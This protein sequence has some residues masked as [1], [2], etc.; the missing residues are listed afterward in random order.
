MNQTFW[1]NCYWCGHA[2]KVVS[3]VEPTFVVC[4]ICSATSLRDEEA[5]DQYDDGRADPQAEPDQP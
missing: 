2:S 4:A 1:V 5:N 3:T